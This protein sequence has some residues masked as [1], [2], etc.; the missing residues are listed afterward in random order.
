MMRCLPPWPAGPA[1]PRSVTHESQPALRGRGAPKL[2]GAQ[3]RAPGRCDVLEVR[4]PTTGF[5]C[6]SPTTTAA[7]RAGLRAGPRRCARHGSLLACRRRRRSCFAVLRFVARTRPGRPKRLGI[8]PLRGRVPQGPAP[9]GSIT[10]ET[11][12][13]RSPEHGRSVWRAPAPSVKLA[14]AGP[15]E[16]GR[17]RTAKSRC[18]RACSSKSL[19]ANGRGSALCY[20]GRRVFSDASSRFRREL[21]ISVGPAPR[22]R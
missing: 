9:G 12:R 5:I 10:A 20:D 8:G 6:R 2:G 16:I 13:C 22:R 11:L 7:K 19:S 15:A 17:V 4:R 21:P 14:W 18:L 3:G 1:S